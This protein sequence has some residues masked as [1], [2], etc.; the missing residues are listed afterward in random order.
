MSFQ[1]YLVYSQP[2]W[3]ADFDG[4]HFLWDI[5]GSNNEW[6]LESLSDTP[7]DVC[8]HGFLYTSYV[9]LLFQNQWCK[10]ITGFYVHHRLANVLTTQISGEAAKFIETIPDDLLAVA[11]QELLGHFY[12]DN[13]SPL[14]EQLIR[15]QW[16]NDPFTRGSHTF[17]KLGS[18]IHDIK[19]LAMPWPNKP[20]KPL[21]LFAGEGTHDRFY[22]T[23]HGA[24]LTGVREAQRLVQLYKS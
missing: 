19:Q 13:P 24:Y 1:I 6:E 23:A 7:F 3:D 15:S 18:S 12:P 4:F 9:D 2:F 8:V 20:A 21:V 10:S 17:I 14:P 22:G 16:F 5:N 11:L